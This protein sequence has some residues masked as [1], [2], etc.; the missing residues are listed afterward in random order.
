MLVISTS[1]LCL[2]SSTL[3]TFLLSEACLKLIFHLPLGL[4]LSYPEVLCMW[5]CKG[6]NS[7]EACKSRNLLADLFT[8]Y[9]LVEGTIMFVLECL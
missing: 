3:L 9:F 4:F 7:A 2:F 5:I 8:P 6:W 1:E